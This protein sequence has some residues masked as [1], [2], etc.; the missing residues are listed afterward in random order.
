M[1]YCLF[2]WNICKHCLNCLTFFSTNITVIIPDLTETRHSQ[3]SPVSDNIIQPV[4]GNRWLLALFILQS[5]CWSQPH[6]EKWYCHIL[7]EIWISCLQP[8]MTGVPVPDL[9]NEF[10]LADQSQSGQKDWEARD[11]L[12]FFKVCRSISVL[13]VAGA[14]F[15]IVQNILLIEKIKILISSW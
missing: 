9:E 3:I 13:D 11:H 8:R 15:L 2:F 1:L 10:Q 7:M 5:F 6:L 4:T 14:G 12:L